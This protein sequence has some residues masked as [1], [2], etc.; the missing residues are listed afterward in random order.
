MSQR[1]TQA[2]IS[3]AVLAKRIIKERQDLEKLQERVHNRE[4]TLQTLGEQVKKAQ[5]LI[6]RRAEKLCNST[7]K[8]WLHGAGWKGMELLE[9]NRTLFVEIW[10]DCKDIK[11]RLE[12]AGLEVRATLMGEHG[13]WHRLWASEKKGGPALAEGLE[14][15]MKIESPKHTKASMGR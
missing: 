3:A 15:A 1:L 2:P 4:A 11:H 5:G 13:T 9:D 7:N 6:L 10:N 14:K 8:P 12:T